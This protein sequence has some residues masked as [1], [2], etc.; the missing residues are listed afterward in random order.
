M[1][2]IHARTPLAGTALASLVAIA[3]AAAAPPPPK[4]V[5]DAF[6]AAIVAANP[7]AQVTYAA[8]AVAGNDI[9]ITGINLSSTEITS[10]TI[11]KVTIVNPAAAPNGG[12]TADRVN[13]EA[14]KLSSQNTSL[15]WQS[16]SATGII[17]PSNA[18]AA[19]QSGALPFA[20]LAMTGMTLT[21]TELAR[22]ITIAGST[23]TV[24]APSGDTKVTVDG[25]KVPIAAFD[26]SSVLK[27]LVK[28][29]GYTADFT[30][31]IS[32]SSTAAGGDGLSLR[33]MDIVADQVGKLAINARTSGV[34]ADA[35]AKTDKVGD[36]IGTA[37]LNQLSIRFDNSGV[38][39]RLLDAQAKAQGQKRAELVEVWTQ[40][41]PFFLAIAGVTNEPL[42][43]K[44]SGAVTTF[45]KTP[46]S[47]TISLKLSSPL[48]LTEILS[49][50]RKDP[51]AFLAKLG[52][53]VTANN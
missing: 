5:A 23:M 46:K 41:L 10:G 43:N 1:G 15:A 44:V 13:V 12:F 47:L 14:G 16:G 35:L 21:R 48:A 26:N 40:A 24:T 53:E 27:D 51:D 31:N 36:I 34:T 29:L 49:T 18:Q 4:Q 7:Q 17:L 19:A 25:I 3:T 6:V 45:L 42:Q 32:A 50:A 30:I 28:S 33:S 39:D 11:G 22:P 9:T 52:L 2:F 38:V 8:A 20:R 37:S